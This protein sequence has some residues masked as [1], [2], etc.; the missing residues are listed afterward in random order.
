M[1]G[2]KHLHFGGAVVVVALVAG[3]GCAAVMYQDA[4]TVGKGKVE[5]TPTVSRVGNLNDGDSNTLG[6]AYGGMI[7]AGVSDKVD[8][9]AGYQR[10]NPNG[11]GGGFNFAGLGAKFSMAKDKA[12]FLLP[13]NFMFGDDVEV[14]D[15]IQ[16][17]PTAVFSVPLGK[18]VTFNPAAKVVWSNCED[19]EV[20]V[21]G[22]AG[23]SVPFASG[24]AVLRPE[25]GALKN[26]GESGLM[27][28]FGLGLSLR[29]R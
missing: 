26:P 12:A 20:L 15:T 25:I 5:F 22:S 7:T 3:Q 24:R 14:S 9:I 29:S 10:L 18:S 1:S 21:G 19:C 16:V 23:F 27:W 17:S 6:T 4:K 2:F 11:P 13:V 28:T 8:L